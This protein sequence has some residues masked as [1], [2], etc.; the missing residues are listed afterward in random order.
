MPPKPRELQER[1][2]FPNSTAHRATFESVEQ[3]SNALWAHHIF[4]VYVGCCWH[5]NRQFSGFIK[6]TWTTAVLFHQW[7]SGKA[8]THCST[9]SLTN[10]P[11]YPPHQKKKCFSNPSTRFYAGRVSWAL[12][13]QVRL[14]VHFSENPAS[15]DQDQM[16]QKVE[17]FR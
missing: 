10:H 11:P 16:L 12:A 4:H 2:I 13:R 5:V 15:C 1:F 9:G 6:G 14:L 8:D 17:Q 7:E 3:Y